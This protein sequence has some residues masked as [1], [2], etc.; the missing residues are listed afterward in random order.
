M[1]TLTSLDNRY[2]ELLAYLDQ[3]DALLNVAMS[4][5]LTDIKPE[6]AHNFLCVASDTLQHARTL[7]EKIAGHRVSL[8]T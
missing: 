5:D 7:T 1:P 8:E 3:A 4:A 6:I 2:D